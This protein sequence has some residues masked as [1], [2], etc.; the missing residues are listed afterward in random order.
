[1]GYTLEHYRACT[2]SA[3]KS[4]IR[5]LL[6]PEDQARLLQ[7]EQAIKNVPNIPS[8]KLEAGMT[9]EVQ[10]EFAEADAIELVKTWE[11]E[12]EDRELQKRQTVEEMVERLQEAKGSKIPASRLEEIVLKYAP[13][14]PRQSDLHQT[15]QKTIPAGSKLPPYPSELEQLIRSGVAYHEDGYWLVSRCEKCGNFKTKCC[16]PV[17]PIS[18]VRLGEKTLTSF[19]RQAVGLDP[20]KP[21]RAPKTPEQLQLEAKQ[22]MD[23]NPWWREFR[24][25]NELEGTGSVKMHIENFLPEGITLI[26]GLPK[27][28]KSFL[29][30]SVAKAL[31]SGQPLFGRRAFEVPEPIP[32]LYLAA[33][34]GDGALKLRC[35][36]MK[37]TSDKTMFLCRTL[38]QGLMLGLND[39]LIEAVIKSMRPIVFLETLIRF[40]DGTD[41]DSASENRK[42]AE[43]LFR[44]I[45][46]G[47]RGVVGIHHSRKDLDK[48]HPT[49]ESAVRG[50]GDGLAMVDAVWL[51]MQDERLHQGGKGPNEVDVQGWGRD[52]T[53][54][55]LRLALTRKKAPGDKTLDEFSPGIVSCL[56]TDGDLKWVQKGLVFTQDTQDINERISQ[57]IGETP[58][59]TRKELIQKTSLKEWQVRDALKAL[60]Y[61]RGRGDNSATRWT[62]EPE[63]KPELTL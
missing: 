43:S 32:V 17:L 13:D 5:G 41:E 55:P 10:D 15:E 33:E 63:T 60:G 18:A 14:A 28:G 22:N 12:D 24:S 62:K 42:L 46:W 26:C 23:K 31:T 3:M 6:S 16:G 34:S 29:A 7:E 8:T 56:D 50:S 59:I 4:G 53:P 40:N 47:A 44:L 27:E 2:D 1:M 35:Q 54:Q 51:V 39:P 9:A 19:G 36:K 45:G 58:T 49:K 20:I 11:A 52:F 38:S 48:R 30:L 37:I 21:P 61:R 25:S 57:L